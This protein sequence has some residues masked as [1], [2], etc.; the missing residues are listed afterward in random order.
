MNYDPEVVK[1][2]REEMT[3]NGFRELLTPEDVTSELENSEGTA[4]VFVNSVCGCS[5]RQARPGVLGAVRSENKPAKLLTVFAGQ[6]KDATAEA[7][8]YFTGYTPSSPQ[9]AL[10]KDGKIVYMME[11]H[12][13]EARDAEM[14]SEQL[15]EEFEKYCN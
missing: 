9:I 11:R 5:A 3:Q 6:D 15:M 8:K 2:M 10:L 1:P 7:R 12:D 4:I 14:I 13:I